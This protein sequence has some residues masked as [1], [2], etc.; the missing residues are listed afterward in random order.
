[1][2]NHGHVSEKSLKN[3]TPIKKGEIRNPKGRP[4]RFMTIA[5]ELPPDCE[6]RVYAKLGEV[7]TLR[8]EAEVRKY[9]MKSAEE[10]GEYG[11]VMQ[12]ACKELLR[13]GSGFSCLMQI[14]DRLFGKP[15]IKADIKTEGTGYTIIVNN[16]SEQK[17]IED[18][19]TLEV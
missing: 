12:L 17:Q 10:M 1:M 15:K 4:T 9:L 19:G 14:C 8:N 5:K 11:I 13:E 7:L 2:A 16:P 18:I 6:M 3:L